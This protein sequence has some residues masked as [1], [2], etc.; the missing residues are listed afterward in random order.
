MALG[1]CEGEADGK[2]RMVLQVMPHEYVDVLPMERLLGPAVV[3]LFQE[4]HYSRSFA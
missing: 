1:I 3:T 4:F 2:R